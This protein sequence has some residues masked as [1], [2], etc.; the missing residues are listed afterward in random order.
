LKFFKK[1]KMKKG[2]T[3][4]TIC[5]AVFM[6]VPAC[7]KNSYNVTE[8]TEVTDRALVKIAYYVGN[9][10]NPVAQVKV[11]G[12][13]VSPALAYNI[14]FPGGGLNTLG[15]SNSDFL[16]LT[17]GMNSVVVSLPKA[18]TEEDSVKIFESQFDFKGSERQTLFLVDSFPK[19]TGVLVNT[20]TPSPTDSG[21]VRIKFVHLIPNVPVVDLY[22]GGVLVKAG[23]PYKGSSEFLDVFA[24][25]QQ[26]TI[27]EPGS[28]T[29]LNGSP[30]N[31]NPAAGRIYTF[32]SRGFKGKTGALAPNVSAIVIK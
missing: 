14:P 20:E 18:G 10:A 15:S 4:L 26:Y 5:L 13:R 9:A 3:T 23:I 8:R 32:F 25:G 11:N 2:L 7:K 17:P 16:T 30:S 29:N 28:T 1:S 22:R 6:A 24:G 12:Q 19:V 31:I 21:K 27:R